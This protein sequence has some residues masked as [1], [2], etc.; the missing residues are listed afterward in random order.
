MAL[1]KR[2][3]LPPKEEKDLE[4]MKA[5]REAM[6]AKIDYLSAMIDVDFYEDEDVDG[7]FD[8]GGDEL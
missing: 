5:D 2:R 7:T 8:E 1:F 6:N 4:N 3:A